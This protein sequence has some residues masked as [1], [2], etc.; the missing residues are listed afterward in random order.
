MAP[1]L[2]NPEPNVN[3]CSPPPGPGVAHGF[4]AVGATVS[5]RV[6][7]PCQFRLLGDVEDTVAAGETENFGE[8]CGEEFPLRFG[9]SFVRSGGEIDFSAPG[10]DHQ[11]SVRQFENAPRL[12]DRAG[13][14]WNIQ[15]MVEFLLPPVCLHRRKI[16]G[17][18]IL[19]WFGGRLRGGGGAEHRADE[20]PQNLPTKHSPPRV[21]FCRRA[22]GPARLT[23]DG[24]PRRG[25]PRFRLG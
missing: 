19:R 2:S 12:H 25:E 17:V 22:N 5:V 20:G 7:D 24:R 1:S 14:H 11:P 15:D 8:P 9:R 23:R 16:V 21:R 18:Q 6:G 13:R 10:A 4:K 3:S